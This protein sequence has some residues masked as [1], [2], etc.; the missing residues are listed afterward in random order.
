MQCTAAWFI[1]WKQPIVLCVSVF[2]RILA[3]P[4]VVAV[5]ELLMALHA[6]VSNTFVGLINPTTAA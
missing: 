3:Q 1:F 4:Q 5:V 2:H 6:V